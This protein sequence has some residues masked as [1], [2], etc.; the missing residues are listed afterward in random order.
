[1][2]TKIINRLK[3]HWNAVVDYGIPEERIIGVFLYGSQ[4]YGFATE[5][6]DIDSKA[7]IIPSVLFYSFFYS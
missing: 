7:I 1:M 3:E 5:E 4:N 2:K 6:S